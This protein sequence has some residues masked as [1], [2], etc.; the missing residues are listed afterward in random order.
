MKAQVIQYPP[1]PKEVVVT[2]TYEEA[3]NLMN[4]PLPRGWS[5]S[6]IDELV[7]ALRRAGL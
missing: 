2:M 5:D 3:Q 1:P 7:F 6:F 4:R